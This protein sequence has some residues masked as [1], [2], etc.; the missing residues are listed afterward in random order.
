MIYVTVITDSAGNQ[1]VTE[2]VSDKTAPIKSWSKPKIR[3]TSV[4][5]SVGYHYTV[6]CT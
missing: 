6:E 5:R 3:T 4:Q 1:F 2:W